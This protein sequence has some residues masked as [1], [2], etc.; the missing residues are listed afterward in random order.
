MLEGM[1]PTQAE[2]LRR[3]RQG[4][5][6]VHAG[7]GR[8]GLRRGHQLP[9]PTPGGERL[10][11]E[12]HPPPV[13]PAARQR[14]VRGRSNQVPGRGRRPVVGRAVPAPTPGP[15]PPTPACRSG[16][17]LLQRARHRPRARRQPG[18]GPRDRHPAVARDR[19]RPSP[20]R[21][22]TWT[23]WWRP[24]PARSPPGPTVI[25]A[26]RRDLLW[27]VA[28]ELSSRRGDLVAAMV[29]EGHKTIAEADPEV[30]EAVDFARWYGER[31]LDLAGAGSGQCRLGRCGFGRC[32]F[33]RCGVRGPA[34]LDGAGSGAAGLG[35]EGLATGR[36]GPVR[37]LR[38]RTGGA[39]VELPGG[40]PVRGSVRGPGRGQRGDPQ[41]GARDARLRRGRGRVLLGRGPA[42]GPGLLHPGARRQRGPPPGHSSRGACRDLD[43]G[44]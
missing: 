35:G 10:G 8:A 29:H 44:L 33:G 6:A 28:D 2:L 24:P 38:S 39:A 13:R 19:P 37:A 20:I 15:P 43:R 23:G 40:H 11:G 21:S 41:A 1:A 4:S 32:G 31:A 12:L 30:S 17:R 36:P 26:E 18:M 16:R 22:P 27:R 9:V 3:R 34:G 25:P 42:R 5:A 7:G 14:R